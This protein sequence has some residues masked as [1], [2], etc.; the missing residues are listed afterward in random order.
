M[1]RGVLQH[2]MRKFYL[3]GWVYQ[4]CGP[5]SAAPSVPWLIIRPEHVYVNKGVNQEIVLNCGTWQIPFRETARQTTDYICRERLDHN[6]HGSW[7][8]CTSIVH[9]W[10]TSCCNNAGNKTERR[11]HTERDELLYNTAVSFTLLWG[12]KICCNF[13]P[14]SRLI[15][16]TVRVGLQDR[17]KVIIWQYY[18][19][20]IES[21]IRAWLW[22]GTKITHSVVFFGANHKN[23]NEDRPILL[24][25]KI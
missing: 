23:V 17:I 10:R 12:R 7:C 14:L 21:R 8:N 22:I 16:E 20:L 13:Q 25:T 24:A 18:D 15:S 9:V 1:G 3:F 11:H 6:T 4:S 19:W 5:G 2:Y